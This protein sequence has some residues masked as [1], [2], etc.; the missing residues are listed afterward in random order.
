MAFLLVKGGRNV[1]FFVKGGRTTNSI[2][3]EVSNIK[4]L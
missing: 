3:I 4:N 1:I 2:A